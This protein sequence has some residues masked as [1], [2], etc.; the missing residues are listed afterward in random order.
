MDIRIDLIRV[1]AAIQ[2]R[3]I[4]DEVVYSLDARWD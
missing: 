3:V 4:D 2:Q 1:D